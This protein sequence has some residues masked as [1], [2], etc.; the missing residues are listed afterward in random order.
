VSEEQL[1]RRKHRR[2]NRRR[3]KLHFQEEEKSRKRELAKGGK[4]LYYTLFAQALENKST[5]KAEDYYK[6]IIAADD[7]DT[8]A[9]GKMVHYYRAQKEYSKLV[10]LQK[11]RYEK[12]S[13]N[14]WLT[15]SYAQALR[16]QG[17]KENKHSNYTTAYALYKQLGESEHLDAHE[18]L[19]I[20]GGEIDCLFKQGNYTEAKEAVIRVMA[21]YPLPILPYLIVYI[22]CLTEEGQYTQANDAF[23][24]LL[25]GTE[26]SLL[27]GDPIYP[28]LQKGNI[29]I[30]LP[31]GKTKAVESYGLNKEEL[32]D[33]YYA[34]VKLYE[35]NGNG[36][37]KNQLL[38]T[39]LEIDPNN[40]FA[41]KRG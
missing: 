28:Y 7:S 39:I 29:L 24:V 22:R 8:N 34:M 9:T 40:R 1:N 4:R 17:K 6:D 3:R 31:T 16:L 18:K 36:G 14:L 15:V 37:A 32:F 12:E 26:S 20:Y 5:K 30:K 38:N 11:Q 35:K 25:E 33:I 23:Q 10:Q 13:G 21:P 27:A 2:G 41:Q 19:V